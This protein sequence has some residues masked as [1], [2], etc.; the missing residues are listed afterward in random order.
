MGTENPDENVIP[1]EPGSNETEQAG[2][3]NQGV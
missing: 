2:L 3:E 1:S